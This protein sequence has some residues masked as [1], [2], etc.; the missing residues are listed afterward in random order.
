MCISAALS[1][2]ATPFVYQAAT[3]S[4]A[5]LSS[6]PVAASATTY[7]RDLAGRLPGCWPQVLDA[8]TLREAS[9]QRGKHLPPTLG[10]IDITAHVI[11]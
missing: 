8:E 9:R 10:L 2:A 6:T 5:A 4:V 11:D 7:A 3:L 1:M